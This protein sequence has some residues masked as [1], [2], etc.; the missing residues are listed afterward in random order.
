MPLHLLLDLLAL[1]VVGMG[2]SRALP[3][4][5]VGA[6]ATAEH[7]NGPDAG[8]WAINA[9]LVAEGNLGSVDPHRMPT[10]LLLTAG[11][12]EF[13]PDVARA[14]HLVDVA[15]WG[16]LP[17]VVFLLGRATGGR[18]VG[19]AAAFLT[20][21][22][23]PLILAAARYGV[24]PVV[25]TCLPIAMVAVAPAQRWWPWAGVAGG[26]AVFGAATHLT[27]V[28]YVVPPLLLLLARGRDP[29]SAPWTRVAAVVSYAA[30]V[31]IAAVAV[32]HLFGLID[33]RRLSSALSEGI[34]RQGGVPV[35]TLTLTDAAR[36]TLLERLPDAGE[37]MLA[38]LFSPFSAQGLPLAASMVMVPLGVLGIGLGQTPPASRDTEATAR[39]R[40]PGLLRSRLRPATRRSWERR[41]TNAA[42]RL[43]G[44]PLRSALVRY[45]RHTDLGR[46]L[47]LLACLAPAP[48]LAVAG[49]EA[50][51]TANLLPLAAV[52]LARGLVAPLGLLAGGL[53]L[54][55]P[56]RQRSLVAL[57]LG[58]A[59]GLLLAANALRA[60]DE[61]IQSLP[62]PDPVAVGARELALA[63]EAAFP[64]AGGVA[65]PVRE[66]AAH[67]GR[68]YC[69]RASCTAQ[70]DV[71][72]I[73]R[74]IHELRVQCSGTGDIPLVWFRRGP[75][76]MGDDALAQEVGRWAAAHYRVVAEF[77]TA[78]FDAVLISV[79]RTAPEWEPSPELPASIVT[80]P[81]GAG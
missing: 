69:P 56:W 79:P 52:L 50:R 80:P 59:G 4:L 42:N 41:W 71:A 40:L 26:L 46:G 67:M 12:L 39:R 74:C 62:R 24:D 10:F 6:H 61:G 15:A 75:V 45:G 18:L 38:S 7:L 25:A 64:E 58:A 16:M 43:A 31:A 29:R 60:L 37:R 77:E 22:S 14:G 57:A 9:L 8:E 72:G 44:H 65:T 34:H 20:L 48:L 19:L 53:P 63:V 73:M 2:L 54:R 55:A 11:A 70:R 32:E 1:A 5:P 78:A 66:A 30:G 17:F 47:S 36:S 28:P 49:A 51:Y 35:E 3:H 81:G 76:G 23:T 13:E 27:A 33:L 21:G 68:P